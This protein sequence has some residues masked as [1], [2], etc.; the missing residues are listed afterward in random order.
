MKNN[1]FIVIDHPTQII[2]AIGISLFLKEKTHVNLLISQHRYWGEINRNILNKY[3]KNSIFL[4]RPEYSWILPLHLLKILKIKKLL[5]CNISIKN[6]PIFIFLSNKTWIELFI[7]KQFPKSKKIALF[8][9]IT[10]KIYKSKN[11]KEL[12]VSRLW[13]II[14]KLLGIP[15]IH[16]GVDIKS[17]RHVTYYNFPIKKYFHKI[18]YYKSYQKGISLNKNELW[19]LMP[20]V[21]QSLSKS[22]TNKNTII[23]FGD[24]IN[25]KKFS[26]KHIN[27][28]NNCLKFIKK[29]NPGCIYLYKPHPSD[30]LE[31]KYI[32]LNGFKI[33]KDKIPAEIYLLNNYS[34][35]KS[36][37][38]ISSL[39]IKYSLTMS[40]PSY[41]FLL[42]YKKLINYEMYFALL[43]QTENIEKKSMISSFNNRPE[44]FRYKPLINIIRDPLKKLEMNKCNE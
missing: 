6:N 26:K 29:N 20:F 35:I 1:I 10:K 44:Y 30:T 8:P 25:K 23:F 24:A 12:L 38:S 21:G 39:A 42:L 2:N 5:S 32:N 9:D 28:T 31:M 27:F 11:I 33:L 22:K 7:I 43:S 4:P 34:K 18:L 3:F 37:Y 19:D 16:Y 41:Y 13:H 15:F 14:F 40:I 17:G 36:C